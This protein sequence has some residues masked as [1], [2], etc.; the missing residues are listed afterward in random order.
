MPTMADVEV[1]EAAVARRQHHGVRGPHGPR[2][3]GR[4]QN[5]FRKLQQA[6]A[7]CA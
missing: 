4:V 1:V 7:R 6:R 5:L 2:G 3:R